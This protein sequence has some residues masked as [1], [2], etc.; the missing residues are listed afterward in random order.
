MRRKLANFINFVLN[1]IK[2]IFNAKRMHTCMHAQPSLCKV[3][4]GQLCAGINYY[5]YYACTHTRMHGP[6]DGRKIWVVEQH[7]SGNFSVYR[8]LNEFWIIILQENTDGNDFETKLSSWYHALLHQAS[9]KR[10]QEAEE[11]CTHIPG[12]IKTKI[13]GHLVSL[14]PFRPPSL[15][16]SDRG[17]HRSTGGVIN[18]CF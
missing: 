3:H 15:A 14:S 18:N 9:S 6:P 17:H 2:I 1:W 5:Y 8:E 7:L 4:A 16:R 10:V 12:V 11:V 13:K